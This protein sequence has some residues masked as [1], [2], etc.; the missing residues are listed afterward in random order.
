MKNSKI[1][2]I[3][4]DRTHMR[5]RDEPSKWSIK[6]LE[7]TNFSSLS[8]DV[9]EFVPGKP[10]KLPTSPAAGEQTSDAGKVTTV[11]TSEVLPVDDG[12]VTSGSQA[13]VSDVRT[14]AHEDNPGQISMQ[15]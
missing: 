8:V 13:L 6:G 11:E 1:V 12:A 5:A 7:A 4:S 10:F 9:P 3:S 2:E 15:Y 14:I